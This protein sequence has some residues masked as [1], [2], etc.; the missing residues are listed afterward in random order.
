MSL[1]C[2]KPCNG[3][4]FFLH[5]KS[6]ILWND[7]FRVFVLTVSILQNSFFP[8]NW[9]EPPP[10]VI[11]VTTLMST[12]LMG[13]ILNT[14]LNLPTVPTHQALSILLLTIFSN[15][16]FYNFLICLLFT[17]GLFQK[18][19]SMRAAVSVCFFYWWLQCT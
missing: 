12:Y 13:I 11:N 18:V 5:S 8:V 1:S 4:I 10:N 16:T 3:F 2:S 14:L 6:Q 19:N 7:L 9:C 15:N 17:E